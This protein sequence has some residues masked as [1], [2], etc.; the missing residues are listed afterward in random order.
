MVAV[1]ES[2]RSPMI[3]AQSNSG[4]HTCPRAVMVE[5]MEKTK[6]MRPLLIK[7]SSVCRVL[8]STGFVAALVLCSGHCGLEEG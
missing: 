4:N 1:D 6:M 7:C 5:S 3:V 2:V 8:M